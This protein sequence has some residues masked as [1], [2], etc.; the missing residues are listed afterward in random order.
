MNDPAHQP[1]R[2]FR[3]QP[4]EAPHLE[5][6]DFSSNSSSRSTSCSGS[7]FRLACLPRKPASGGFSPTRLYPRGLS[8]RGDDRR[9]IRK[10]RGEREAW[11]CCASGRTCARGWDGWAGFRPDPEPNQ[12]S[13][14][15]LLVPGLALRRQP[16]LEGEPRGLRRLKCVRTDPAFGRDGRGRRQGAG[17]RAHDRAGDREAENPETPPCEGRAQRRVNRKPLARPPA[18]ASG[19]ADLLDGRARFAQSR[20]R[21]AFE[22]LRKRPRGRDGSR[23]GPSSNSVKDYFQHCSSPA[24]ARSR[25]ARAARLRRRG[26]GKARLGERPRADPAHRITPARS[27]R[28]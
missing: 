6:D 5:R 16:A 14:A 25:E 1:A 10:P 20:C 18:T 22:R 23:L 26:I 15:A 28:R 3:G 8:A 4:V 27:S 13:R 17:R 9:S 12:T 7:C 24:A 21:P 11:S 19:A 2:P